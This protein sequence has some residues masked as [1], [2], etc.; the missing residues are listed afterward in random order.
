MNVSSMVCGSEGTQKTFPNFKKTIDNTVTARGWS[1]FLIHGIDNDGG[2]SPLPFPVLDSALNYCKI[3]NYKCW[4]NT[5][6]NISRYIKER[7]T[8]SVTEIAASET[9]I[10]LKVTDTL[11]DSLY[12]YPISIRRLLPEKWSNLTVTQNGK[13]VRILFVRPDSVIFVIFNVVP[14]GGEIKLLRGT[15]TAVLTDQNYEYPET[16]VTSQIMIPEKGNA[17]ARGKLNLNYSA[18]KLRFELPPGCGE[19]VEVSLFNTTGLLMASFRLPNLINSQGSIPL[20]GK[21][22]RPGYYIVRITDGS[23]SWSQPVYL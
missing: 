9:A 15:G 17:S 11:N 1:V 12:N 13:D 2:Y 6:G 14:D 10:T 22:V 18:G 7:N 21:N 3:R 16:T 8:A 20:A 19:N 5:F 23:S 4:V